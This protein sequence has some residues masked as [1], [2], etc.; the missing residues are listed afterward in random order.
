MKKEIAVL[1]LEKGLYNKP[2]DV[3]KKLLFGFLYGSSNLVGKRCPRKVSLRGD[4]EK[5]ANRFLV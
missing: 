4:T 3:S 2:E 1:V 5:L